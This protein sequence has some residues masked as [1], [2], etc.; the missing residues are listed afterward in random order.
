MDAQQQAFDPTDRGSYRH[1]ADERVRFSDLDPLGHVN[2]NAIGIYF[3]SGRLAFFDAV[4]LH[5]G[6]D[7]Q[8]SVVVRLAIDFR[9]ELT[10]PASLDIGTRLVRL[11][12]SSLTYAQGLF[13]DGRCIATAE[14]V[15]VLFDL[16][17]RRPEALG[18]DQRDRL[19][20]WF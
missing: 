5:E 7:H 3:E 1:W 6:L 12:S 17:S 11:G 13:A 2:N 10:W 8:R 14:T 16:R 9:A 18:Q 20:A 4:R 15:S 19:S